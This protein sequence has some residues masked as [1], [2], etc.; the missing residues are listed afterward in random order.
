M[1]KLHKNYLIVIIC[2]AGLLRLV[3]LNWDQG[4]HLHPDERMITM[5]VGRISM[6]PIDPVL[7]I[8]QKLN[9][10]FSPDSTLNPK[11]FAYGSFPIYLLKF[12]AHLLTPI[13]PKISSYDQINL[14]GRAISAVFDT[15]VIIFIYRLG[16][17][18]FKSSSKSLFASVIYGLSIFP[19]QLSHFYAVDTI[20]SFFILFTIYQLIC[21]FRQQR[22]IN[23]LF[24]GVGFGL[25]LATKVSAIV[26]VV[27]F[28]TCFTLLTWRFINS[29]K[30]LKTLKLL[31]L[32][33]A[34]TII[35]FFIFQPFALTDF[36]TFKRQIL[37]QQAMTKDAFVFPYT[38]Q[39]VNTIPYLY[40][41]KNI[42][43][44]G[45]GPV[46]GLMATIGFFA[47]IKKLSRGLFSPGS[48]NSPGATIILFSFFITYFIIVGGFAVKW[49]RYCLPLY[50]IF[51][52]FAAN[53]IGDIKSKYLKT[54]ILLIHLCLVFAF[55]SIYQVPN[56][57]VTATKWINKNIS[58][59]STILVEHW[60]DPLPLGYLNKN[61]TQLSLPLYDSDLEPNKWVNINKM[62]DTGDYIILSS[63]RL[64]T[65]LQKLT[66]CDQLPPGRCYSKTATYYQD[67][68]S[69]KLGYTKVAEF[70][71][72]PKLFGISIDDQSADES[73]TVYDHPKVMIYK[74]THVQK[75]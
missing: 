34:I 7:K 35:V 40:P 67:L 18:I 41:L 68:F 15:L 65:P 20:L 6:P 44:W 59:G 22:F 29:K 74:N 54:T 62:L 39:Y 24:A 56:T 69:G 31:L 60:D 3:G 32:V 75:N 28:A 19:I 26:L 8:G 50:P 51:A 14:L 46:I 10:L 70:T 33:S 16:L 4:N 9:I 43:L 12:S 63:N 48:Q 52:L 30:I 17:L 45:L 11:F 61:I 55:M 49:M 71:N 13:F 21:Y 58:P 2:V 36:S 27:P 42:F 64:Y 1:A 5:V 57:R 38:L 25:S 72:Y 47:L 73:F 53:T 66:N 37:E 23:L